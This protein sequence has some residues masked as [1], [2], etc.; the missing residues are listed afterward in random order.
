MEWRRSDG[1]SV[2]DEDKNPQTQPK[3]I[4]IEGGETKLEA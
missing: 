3:K 1:L 4:A 2:W